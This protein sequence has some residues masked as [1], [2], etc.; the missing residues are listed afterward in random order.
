MQDVP[1]SDAADGPL[2]DFRQM[3]L[4]IGVVVIGVMVV[5]RDIVGLTVAVFDF[6]Q[7]GHAF[8]L[9]SP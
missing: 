5:G 1:A 7:M 9:R 6:V 8:P 4:E 3:V 2:N